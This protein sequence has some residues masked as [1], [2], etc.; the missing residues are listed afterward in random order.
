MDSQIQDFARQTL[1]NGLAKLPESNRIIF[2]RLY[3]EHGNLNTDI[4]NVVDTMTEDELDWAVNFIRHIQQIQR[5]LD[6]CE[7]YPTGDE[8]ICDCGSDVST[9]S[10]VIVCTKQYSL[11]CQWAN[12]MRRERKMRIEFTDRYKATGIPY[13][14]PETVCLGQCEGMGMVPI[15]KDNTEEPF[16]TLWLEAEAKKPTDDSYHFV[17]C[18]DCNGTRLRP[19]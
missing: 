15:H 2:K 14:N 10:N 1:K 8:P 16:H 17:I 4:S 19:T 7:F 9:G 6:K 12:E 5:S 3:S 11:T 13:P 18:P